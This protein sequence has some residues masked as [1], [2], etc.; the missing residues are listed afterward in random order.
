MVRTKKWAFFG[1]KICLLPYDHKLCQRPFL[2]LRE[3]V[4]FAPWDQFFILRFRVTA[5]FIKKTR[6]TRQKVFPHP[7]VRAMSAS[8]SPSA[9]S[10]GWINSVTDLLKI[11]TWIIIVIIF[12]HFILS[13]TV[14]QYW[15]PSTEIFPSHFNSGSLDSLN[16]PTQPKLWRKSS[17]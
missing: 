15:V 3:T 12:S 16:M 6:P 11:F 4:H 17:C 8:I 10:A 7:I 14:T 2:A 13:N 5:V 9:H 1:M